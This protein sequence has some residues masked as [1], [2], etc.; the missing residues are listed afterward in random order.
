MLFFPKPAKLKGK[1]ITFRLEQ[2]DVKL[3]KNLGR[4][5]LSTTNQKGPIRPEE[6]ATIVPLLEE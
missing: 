4:F 2:N 5:R 6:P 3:P 1:S